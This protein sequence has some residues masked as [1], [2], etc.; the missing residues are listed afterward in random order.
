MAF[1]S[2]R[3]LFGVAGVRRS[4]LGF[5]LGTCSG[6]L[7]FGPSPGALGDTRPLAG[8]AAQIIELGAPNYAPANDLDRG[9]ARRI[10]RKN[11][12]YPLAIGD[13]AQSEIRVD[14]GILARDAEPF[15]GLDPLALA[16][17]HS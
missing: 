4:R 13:L 7:E 14:A 6:A 15:E 2:T 5:R 3:L 1:T 8:A 10:E 16:L 11:A 17:D 12:L 9:D